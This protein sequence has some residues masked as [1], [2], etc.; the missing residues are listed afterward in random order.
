[1]SSLKNIAWV[2]E[3]AKAGDFDIKLLVRNEVSTYDNLPKGLH[4]IHQ[5]DYSDHKSLVRHLQAQDAVIVF[6]SF[7]PG[8]EFDKKH[9]ALV[10]ATIDAGVKYFIPSEWALDTAGKMEST[11][12][13]HGPTLPTDMVLA[14]KR[15]SHNYLL[16]RAAEGKLKFCVVYPGVLFEL[17]FQNGIFAFDFTTHSAL[18]PDNG[19]NPFPATTLETLSKVIMSLFNTPSLISNEFYHVADGVLTQQYVF[20]VVEKEMGVLWAR[21]S[22]STKEF[23]NAALANIQKDVYGPSEYANSLMTPFFGGLQVWRHLDNDKLKVP[24]GQVDVRA[25]LI[26]LVQKQL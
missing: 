2:G 12:D 16:C 20:H 1:M 5:V 10:N 24:D 13:G 14:P 9:I 21:T 11:P 23:R 25:E 18:L 15:V 6:T 22:Y 26:S 17:S 7:V 8:N 19:I 4:S 3:V